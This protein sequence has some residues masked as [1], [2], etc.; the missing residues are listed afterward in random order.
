MTSR[1]VLNELNLDLTTTSLFVRLWLLLVLVIVAPAFVRSIVVDERVIPDGTW[2]RRWMAIAR[3]RV[4]RE[5]STLSFAHGRGSRRQVGL[6]G[7]G[8]HQRI[9]QV[10]TRQR[11]PGKRKEGESNIQ[12]IGQ[13][14]VSGTAKDE[15]LVGVYGVWPEKELGGRQKGKVDQHS[16]L[17]CCILR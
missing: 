15:G 8:L 4:A 17:K 7:H 16:F 3:Y 10:W 2:E 5:V 9:W 14:D 6:C 11:L 1:F 12:Y 13:V